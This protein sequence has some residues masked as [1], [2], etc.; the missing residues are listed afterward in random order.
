MMVADQLGWPLTTA[1]ASLLVPGIL[2]DTRN[3]SIATVTAD[4]FRAVAKLVDAGANVHQ[5]HE[6]YRAADRLSIELLELKARL[7]GRIELY[8]DGKIALIG[9]TPEELKQYA[10]IHDPA[11]LVI[12]DLQNALG[13]AVGVVMRHYGGEANKIK[14]STRA[15]MPV[16][17][18]ACMDFG[19]G[20]HDRAAGCQFTDT[21]FA[22]AKANFVA[23]LRKHIREYE[24]HQHTHQDQATT[25]A[26]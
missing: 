4:T 22:E 8:D 7:L 10:A 26:A 15:N 18:K 19:G 25:S 21:P 12:Y 16:A 2:A 6:D 23:S 13:V 24:T 9:V 11:D 17:A 20:G 3:L 5:I 14:V 1:A